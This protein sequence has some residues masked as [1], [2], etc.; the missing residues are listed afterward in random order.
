MILSFLEA[1]ERY[2]SYRAILVAI[3]SQN[4]FVLAFVGVS[5]K[6]RAI[7]SKTG[8]SHRC[9]CEKIS[10]RGGGYRTF[11]GVPTSLKY[12]RAIWGISQRKYRNIARYGSTKL[13]QR[14]QRSKKFEISIEIENFDREWNFRASHPLRPYFC[15]EIETSRLKFSSEIKYF[16]RDWKFRS[17]SN[18]FDRWALWALLTHPKTT[19]MRLPN[20]W[21]RFSAWEKRLLWER[22]I[23][24]PWPRS[25]PKDLLA[26]H[27]VMNHDPL[28]IGSSRGEELPQERLARHMVMA[29]LIFSLEC[30]LI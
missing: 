19:P 22:K 14:A 27:M 23:R 29:I 20:S 6:Y 12:Y 28:K 2:L 26:T 7:C 8:G 9:A 3:V 18:V 17:R 1:Q 11:G 4:Y 13:S 16:D 5:H 24:W 15:G 10:A 30:D 21:F 25:L